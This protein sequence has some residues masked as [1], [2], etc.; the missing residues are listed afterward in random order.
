MACALRETSYDVLTEEINVTITHGD[1]VPPR[2]RPQNIGLADEAES[3]DEIEVDMT[4]IV[5]EKSPRIFRTLLTGLPSPSSVVWSA[6]TFLINALLVFMVAQLTFQAAWYHPADDLSFAR[7][8]YVSHNEAR[9]FVREPNSTQ[10]PIQLSYRY[11]GHPI[12]KGAGHRP[13][14]SAWHSAGGI[15]ELQEETDFTTTIT[16]GNLRHHSRYQWAL[17]NNRTGYFFTAPAPG[18]KSL[19]TEGV[20][21]TFTFLHSS[22]LIPNFPYKSFAHPLSIPGFRHLAAWLSHIRP[23]FMLFLG[24]FIYVDVPCRHGSSNEDYRRA[25]RQVY[26]SPDWPA[27]SRVEGSLA[28]PSYDL[29]WLHVYDD[30]EIANDWS[31][32]TSGVFPAAFDPYFHYHLRP[33]PP[34]PPASS[35]PDMSLISNDRVLTPSALAYSSI[36]SWS[37]FTQGPATFFLLDTRRYRQQPD[38]SNPWN[39]TRSILGASQLHALKHWLIAPTAPGIH[40]KVLISSVPFTKNWRINAH[41]TWSGYLSERRDILEVMWKAQAESDVGI[42][43]LSGD[44]HEFAATALPPPQTWCE[45]HKEDK[46]AATVHEFCNSPLNMFY[47]PFRTYQEDDAVSRSSWWGVLTKLSWLPSLL[48]NSQ[49]TTEGTTLGAEIDKPHGEDLEHDVCLAYIPAGNSKFGIVDI[50]SATAS[51]QS[52]LRYRAVIDGKEVWSHVLLSGAGKAGRG[53]SV[54]D[55]GIWG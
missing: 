20:K 44:R 40:W 21:N 33:N 51:G 35:T 26:A 43:V 4:Q 50:E 55:E 34:L 38:T 53:R 45:K 19:Q 46:A 27:V 25:Y 28:G 49:K 8:G 11:V 5:E 23:S 31:G 18:T 16:I 22:C 6:L 47:L 17:S 13:Y 14:D 9:I 15:S 1:G 36:P 42:V 10:Y 3:E 24:D 39:P 32:N 7:V 12:S 30:H 54:L 52:I 29:P 41:D 37:I 48:S 2:A